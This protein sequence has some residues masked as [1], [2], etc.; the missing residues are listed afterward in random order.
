MQN[1]QKAGRAW[2]HEG[3]RSLFAPVGLTNM[4]IE[5]GVQANRFQRKS[6]TSP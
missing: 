3:L 5:A 6:V 1:P 2:Q 4:L